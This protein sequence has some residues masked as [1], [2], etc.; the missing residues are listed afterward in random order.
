MKPLNHDSRCPGR[1]S[2]EVLPE[3]RSSMLVL[4]GTLQRLGDT[5]VAC[6][7]LQCMKRSTVSLSLS[8]R[9]GCTWPSGWLFHCFPL[10][11]QE[12][13]GTVP[14]NDPRPIIQPYSYVGPL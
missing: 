8:L 9:F 5:S 14:L 11:L 12:N 1:D 4:E 13:C 3:Y 10:F 2:K 7:G 6:C